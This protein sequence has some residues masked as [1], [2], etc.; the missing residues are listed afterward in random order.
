MGVT[1]IEMVS[2]VP[3]TQLASQNTQSIQHRTN[4]EQMQLAQGMQTQV[5]NNSQKTAKTEKQEYRQDKFDAKDKG[6]NEY[7][8]SGQGKSSKD[9]EE[10]PQPIKLSSFDIKI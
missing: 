5:R 10:K 9:N 2:M 3:K 4:N 6:K 7:Y 1:P 8:Q